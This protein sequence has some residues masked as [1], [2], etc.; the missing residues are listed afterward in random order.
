M[1]INILSLLG[2]AIFCLVFIVSCGDN[3]KSVEDR[4][5]AKVGR[6]YDTAHQGIRH[7]NIQNQFPSS[8][9]DNKDQVPLT[10][11]IS[12]T[13]VDMTDTIKEQPNTN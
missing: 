10:Q 8:R 6:V 1:K 12:D 2:A 5:E 11:G 13:T 7:E 3:K 9:N 4:E